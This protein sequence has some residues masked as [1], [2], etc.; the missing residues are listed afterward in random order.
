MRTR[1][2][3]AVAMSVL[4]AATVRPVQPPASAEPDRSVTTEASTA[5]VPVP[6]PSP[7]AMAYYRSGVALMLVDTLWGVVVPA[8]ILFTGFSARLRNLAARIGRRWF[9][10]VAVYFAL[11]SLVMFAIDFPRAYYE[12]FVRP[13]A[14]E[15]SEQ[16]FSKWFGDSI[17]SL[18]VSLVVGGLF[19]WMPY[20]LLRKSPR[21]LVDLHQPASLPLLA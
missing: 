6:E 4:L 18:L 21:P 11:F 5:P 16:T 10:T 12:D 3:L 2:L 19:L 15:L 1:L 14:Y 8:I 17:K 9:F 7:K 13:H 20:P